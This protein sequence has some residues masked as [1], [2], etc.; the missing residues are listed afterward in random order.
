MPSKLARGCAQGG[1]PELTRDPS[2]YC[3]EHKKAHRAQQDDRRGSSSERGYGSRWQKRRKWYLKHNP[4]CEECYKSGIMEASTIVDHIVPHR[5]DM[6]LFWD[7]GNWQAL[8][9]VHH[10]R[11]TA[12]ESGWGR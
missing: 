11:K 7:E 10:D 1:C 5:G 6:A 2:C 8:C 4:F 3:P 9:K 12:R